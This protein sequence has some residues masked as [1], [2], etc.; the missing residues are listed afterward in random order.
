MIK[1][2]HIQAFKSIKDL[3][4]KCKNLNLIVG[5]NS[6]GK[7]SFIQGILLEAQNSTEQWGL[8]GPL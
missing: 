4:V 5:T 3:T 8:N 1:K 7:S 6:S 2:V